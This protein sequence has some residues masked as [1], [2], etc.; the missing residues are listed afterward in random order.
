MI[1][2]KERKAENSIER[3]Y[4]KTNGRKTIKGIRFEKRKEGKTT[5]IEVPCLENNTLTSTV[6]QL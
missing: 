2:A 5:I 3:Q 4:Q 6:A 1:K